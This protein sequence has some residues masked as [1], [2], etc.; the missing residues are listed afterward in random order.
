[1]ESVTVEVQVAK[2]V[3]IN[4]QGKFHNFLYVHAITM[5]KL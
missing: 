3:K 4:L 2:E 1:M 5:L